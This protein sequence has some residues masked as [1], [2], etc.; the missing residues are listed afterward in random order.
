PKHRSGNRTR[1][2]FP[3]VSRPLCGRSSPD[4]RGSAAKDLRGPHVWAFSPLAKSSS[5]YSWWPCNAPV[6][7]DVCFLRS[8]NSHG[9]KV[10]LTYSIRQNSLA[11]RGLSV[12]NLDAA[13]H[14]RIRVDRNDL[15]AFSLD[16]RR[17]KITNLAV[18]QV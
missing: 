3:V 2:K 5:R 9:C 10:L 17:P 7:V 8:V 18:C 16:H 6:Q 14:Q 1:G 13:V 15:P 12:G 4:T 11:G